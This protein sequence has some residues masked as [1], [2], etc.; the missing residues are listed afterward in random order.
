MADVTLT[1]VNKQADGLHLIGSNF[2][3]TTTTVTVNQLESPYTFISST[4]L[5]ID[6]PAP[7]STIEVEKGGVYSDA[8]TTEEPTMSDQAP[9]STPAANA[10]FS[11]D[12][13]K[14]QFDDLLHNLWEPR[15]TGYD[16]QMLVFPLKLNNRIAALQGY[17]DGGFAPTDNERK[18][19]NELAA[20]L[21]GLLSLLKHLQAEASPK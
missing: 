12:D 5:V 8:I 9:T 1:S 16:D 3:Q 7:G 10:P 13:L 17:T 18:V 6:N 11:A 2:T 19:Y 15:Y 4:E 14:K 21:E 20:D